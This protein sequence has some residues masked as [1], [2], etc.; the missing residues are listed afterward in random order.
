MAR[1]RRILLAIVPIFLGAAVAFGQSSSSTDRAE[2]LG[3]AAR[4]GDAPA[5]KKLLDEGVDVNTK[6]RYGATALSYACDRG[7]LDVVKLLVDRGAD[8]NARD[9][10]YNATPLTWAVNPAM[11]RKPQHPEIVRLLLEHGAQGKGQALIASV[12]APDTATLKV[13]LD[14]GGLPPDALSDALASAKNGKHDDIVAL[15]E[16]AGAKPRV[17]FKIDDAQLSRYAG[18]YRGPGDAELVLT[19]AAGRLAGG[20]Q[21]QR[22]TFVA[23]DATTFGVTEAPGAT[24]TFRL[25][26]EK[27][28][29]I[30]FPSN[31][32]TWTRVEGK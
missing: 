13:I 25:E 29:S 26:G 27:V 19:V 32:T 30:G 28:M 6:F 11:G 23:R 12:S 7:H 8:V 17:E 21:G 4:K 2:A 15:L 3:E 9:T 1:A 20:V 18:T 16:R 31:A 22:L 24:L 10:F 14:S 5:V